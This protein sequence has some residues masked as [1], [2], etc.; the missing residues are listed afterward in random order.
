MSYAYLF[1]ILLLRYIFYCN[2]NSICLVWKMQIGT[3]NS[4]T[5]RCLECLLLPFVSHLVMKITNMISWL[6]RQNVRKCQVS[7]KVH[8]WDKDYYFSGFLSLLRETT[9]WWL[10]LEISIKFVQIHWPQLKYNL[11]RFLPI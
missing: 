3:N 5:I 11:N 7:L 8:C 6:Q 4:N 1:D 2:L 10:S 9:V